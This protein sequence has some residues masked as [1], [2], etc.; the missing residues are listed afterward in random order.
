M[1]KTPILMECG[2]ESSYK[3]GMTDMVQKI[4]HWICQ[5]CKKVLTT[6]LPLSNNPTCS[7][8]HNTI[9]MDKHK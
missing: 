9:E 2:A 3:E 6:Y 8:K 1:A 4:Q 7:N 5:V